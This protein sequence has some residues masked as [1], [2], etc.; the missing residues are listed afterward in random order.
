MTPKDVEVPPYESF[1]VLQD[2]VLSLVTSLLYMIGLVVYVKG[3]YGLTIDIRDEL[4]VTFWGLIIVILY[5]SLRV[6]AYT[7]TRGKG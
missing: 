4:I 6:F 3:Y 7:R 1:D 2:L 5:A